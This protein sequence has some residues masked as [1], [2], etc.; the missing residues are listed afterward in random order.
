MQQGRFTNLVLVLVVGVLLNSAV[1][2]GVSRFR[3]PIDPLLLL[4]TAWGL[5]VAWQELRQTKTSVTRRWSLGK[6]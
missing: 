4:V 3:E 6:F 2:F 1:F 5:Y